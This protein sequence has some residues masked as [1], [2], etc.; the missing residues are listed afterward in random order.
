M[1]NEKGIT[2]IA[3]IITIIVLLIL[4]GVSI[5]MV[6]GENGVLNRAQEASKKA[7]EADAIERINME[8]NASYGLDGRIDTQLLNDN[9]KNNLDGVL[10]NGKEISETNKIETLPVWVNYNG[11]DIELSKSIIAAKQITSENY[12]DKVEYTANGISDWK[13]FYNDGKNIFI[14][15][16]DIL[17]NEKLPNT[18]LEMQKYGTYI[19]SWNYNSIVEYD[20]AKSID[21]DVAKKYLLGWKFNHNDATGSNIKAVACMLD[22]NKWSIFANDFAESSI[23]GPTI[24]MWINSWN[25]LYPNNKLYYDNSS[26]ENGYK[27]SSDGSIFNYYIDKSV[28]QTTDGWK[29]NEDDDGKNLYFPRHIMFEDGTDGKKCGSYWIASNNCDSNSRCLIYI[30]FDGH[31]SQVGFGDTV[32]CFRP[33]VC[34]KSDISMTKDENGV[35]KLSK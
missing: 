10:L 21:Y 35:W 22:T 18:L 27:I 6:V 31:I 34:L 16:T 33:I 20:G 11:V 9:L 8:Y 25:E 19:A 26:N 5:S 29:K 24:E 28:M 30:G 15:T 7:K 1:K 32:S 14:I 4:A 2:L 23:G 17:P 3:L 13:I 12:G